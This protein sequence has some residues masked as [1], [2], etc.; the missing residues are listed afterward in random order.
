MKHFHFIVPILILAAGTYF[1]YLSEK[2]SKEDDPNEDDEILANNP[3]GLRATA[4]IFWVIGMVILIAIGWL[5]VY[6]FK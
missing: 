3:E 1:Y 6:P 2:L 4:V 5:Y